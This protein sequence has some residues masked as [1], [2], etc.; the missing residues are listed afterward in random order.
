MNQNPMKAAR[1]QRSLTDK[2]ETAR[3]RSAGRATR[4]GLLLSAVVGLASACSSGEDGSVDDDETNDGAGGMIGSGGAV[5]SG[6][7][8]S[9]GGQGSGGVIGSGGTTAVGGSTGAGS[10]WGAGGQADASGGDPG[11]GGQPDASG[12]VAGTGGD[13]GSGGTSSE[14]PKT[15]IFL[16]LGQSNMVGQPQP[17]AED[18]VEDPRIQVM[19]YDNCGAIGRS[20]NEWYTASPPLH[21]CDGGV[22]PGDYFA[23]TLL[24]RLPAET[25]IGLVPFAVNGAPIEV[26][27]K[28]V[29][30][31]G[32]T[33]PPDD[34]WPT[35]Y[36]WIMDRATKA[37][38][39]GTIS[40]ILYHQGESDATNAEW[41]AQV[42]QLVADLR[43]DL[44]IGEAAP[45]IIGELLESGCCADRNALIN[46]FTTDIPNTWVAS[47]SGLA[48]TDTYHFDL[49]GQR[50]LG[51]RYAE[52]MIVA[53]GL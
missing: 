16:L 19:A 47:S 40:G 37:Q 23:K 34:H 9:S 48:G 30:R 21:A 3:A 44:G 42:A 43:A 46:Q 18:M 5:G 50:E 41:P 10:D 32:W 35:G 11:T 13:L 51:R 25:S 2:E 36:E 12:G 4:A 28:G 39:V 26:F 7:L 15:M 31:P 14:L 1:S 49:A 17:Q 53:L 6:G 22:G 33:L 29:P 20:Y 27:R 52:E 8:A 38:E 45:F 24:E